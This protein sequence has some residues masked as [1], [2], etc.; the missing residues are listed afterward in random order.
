MPNKFAHQS[1]Q[2]MRMAQADA[3]LLDQLVQSH[4]QAS[5]NDDH[6]Y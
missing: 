6:S 4:G 3:L 1:V 2:G 5:N